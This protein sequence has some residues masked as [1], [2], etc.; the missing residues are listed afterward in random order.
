MKKII[1]IL[2]ITI[3][4][5]FIYDHGKS[6]IFKD[7]GYYGIENNY[8]WGKVNLSLKGIDQEKINNIRI[9][10]KEYRLFLYIDNVSSNKFFINSIVL[11]SDNNEITILKNKGLLKDNKNSFNF[12]KSN[13]KINNY[14]DLKIL[15]DFNIEDK[16]YKIKETL[17][18]KYKEDKITFWDILMGVQCKDPI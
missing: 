18:T 7:Y 14:E 4:T 8:S 3:I 10:G 15:I 13:I 11:N 6:T 16:N 2:I 5:F 17:K 9:R 1:F 12:Y